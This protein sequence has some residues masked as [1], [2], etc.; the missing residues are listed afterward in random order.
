MCIFAPLQGALVGPLASRCSFAVAI[1]QRILCCG[2]SM[3]SNDKI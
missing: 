2:N 3:M 1:V